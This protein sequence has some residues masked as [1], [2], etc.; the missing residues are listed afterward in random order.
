MEVRVTRVNDGWRVMVKGNGPNGPVVAFILAA[1]Y[2]DAIEI[3]GYEVES[4]TLS[5]KPDKY[6]VKPRHS[7]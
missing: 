7:G 1:S 6:P 4:G 5:F 2:P 3:L